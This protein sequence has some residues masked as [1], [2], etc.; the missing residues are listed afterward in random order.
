MRRT[1]QT[2]G[3]LPMSQFFK[4]WRVQSV[5]LGSALVLALPLAG[6]GNDE[7]VPTT[8]TSQPA[9]LTSTEA[10]SQDDSAL[11]A[12]SGNTINPNSNNTL[13]S[14]QAVGPA[15]FTPDAGR[16][17]ASQCAQ[18]HGTSGISLNGIDSLAFEGG[19]EV[20]EE[21][22][23]MQGSSYTND[24]MH[25]QARGYTTNEINQMATWF[26]AQRSTLVNSSSGGTSESDAYPS[27]AYIGHDDDDSS[28]SDDGSSYEVN[29][30]SYESS[31]SEDS[32]SGTD[33]DSYEYN[34]SSSSDDDDHYDGDDDHHDDDDD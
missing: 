13:R 28:S 21:M 27:D 18:C 16:L 14:F 3:F 23:E 2:R 4:P 20:I 7:T 11:Q 12:S 1:K 10:T 34:D 26:D 30:D 22:L 15:T 29:D 5:A 32:S 17:L 8:G 6:C 19:G 31:G 33:H 25:Q 24:I 9:A